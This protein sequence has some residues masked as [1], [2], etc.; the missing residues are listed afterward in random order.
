LASYDMAR[1]DDVRRADVTLYESDFAATHAPLTIAFDADAKDW[2]VARSRDGAM[3][4]DEQV[5][6]PRSVRT[7]CNALFACDAKL[8]D[9]LRVLAARAGASANFTLPRA[10]LTTRDETIQEWLDRPEPAAPEAPENADEAP[11]AAD[12]PAPDA[13]D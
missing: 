12:E 3:I 1:R 8:P 2:L 13:A 6:P 4:G 11:D 5:S 9:A 10:M 7:I